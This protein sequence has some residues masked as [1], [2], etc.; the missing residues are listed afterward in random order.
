ME[1]WREEGRGGPARLG[2]AGA[3]GKSVGEEGQHSV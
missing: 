3:G 1:Y 2:G